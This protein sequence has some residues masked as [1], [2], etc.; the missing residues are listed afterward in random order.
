MQLLS[1]KKI[2]I[3]IFEYRFV[4]ILKNRTRKS[5]LDKNEK[6]GQAF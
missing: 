5:F 4:V 3:Y 6:M 1:Q 2:Y